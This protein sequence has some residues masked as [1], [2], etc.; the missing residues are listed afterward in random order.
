MDDN[1]QP[2]SDTAG[3]PSVA[4]EPAPKRGLLGFIQNLFG[5][6]APAPAKYGDPSPEAPADDEGAPAGS[7]E[8]EKAR[9]DSEERAKEEA[10]SLVSVKNNRL[11]ELY[12]LDR[13]L[14][15]DKREDATF[16]LA[17]LMESGT[18]PNREQ[19][20][21]FKSIEQET[22][23]LRQYD[24]PKEIEGDE[25]TEEEPQE[26]PSPADAVVMVRVTSDKMAAYIFLL[27]PVHGGADMDF[28]TLMESLGANNVLFNI[29]E[30]KL[31][32][33]CDS[34]RY[35]RLIQVAEGELPIDGKD[36][37]IVDHFRRELEIQLTVKD[38]NT[39]DY[40][41]LGWLQSVLV[42][43]IICDIIPP[44]EAI[45]GHNVIGGEIR[46]K[47]GRK[48][49]VPNGQN[50][51]I[52][53][54]GTALVATIDGA[55]SFANGRFRVDPLVIIKG[56]IEVATGNLDVVGDVLIYGDVREG[57]NVKA[58]GNITVQ[59]MVE[60]AILTS[61][62]NI[63]V[64]RGMNGNS[65][66]SMTAK[67]DVLCKFLENVTVTAGG[68]II[69]DTIINSDISS[70]DAII[71]KTGRGSI[72]GG[73]LTALQRIEAKTIG[74]QSNRSI[75]IHMGST[76]AF[77]REKQQNE[78]QIEK[79]EAEIEGKEKNILFLS[80][81]EDTLNPEDA[82]VLDDLR[83]GLSVQRMQLANLKRQVVVLEKRQQD[84]GECRLKAETIYP[85]VSITIGDFSKTLREVVINPVVF[86][87][88]G[89]IHIA[90]I[91]VS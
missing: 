44:T 62:G 35:L 65:Q 14:P 8:E 57:Y 77:L 15:T 26:A 40:K 71:A 81:Y 76:S 54:E 51:A 19:R 3:Q 7:D 88:D 28:D 60:G 55:I 49:N 41:D 12:C 67:G 42:D 25:D 2:G 73:S 64:G 85:P 68:K 33:V 83:L 74:N 17:S 38:D 66:G 84:N 91:N 53:Q 79:T 52:N 18:L 89:E 4:P 43:D 1:L 32:H 11:Y 31:K 45:P 5:G 20:K 10:E 27:P 9:Q 86:L 6:Q 24:P 36:G 75:D 61:G 59:G 46:G 69:C 22:K 30:D 37:E 16:H 63:Q 78:E 80:R 21:W 56:D 48:A 23:A 82:K 13:D 87:K 39:I 70:D 34:R 50:T 29:D 58:T 90:L 47:D 72:I